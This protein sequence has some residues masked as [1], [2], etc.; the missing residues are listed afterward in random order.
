MLRHLLVAC[1]V[2]ACLAQEATRPPRTRPPHT[3]GTRPPRPTR[4]DPCIKI[5]EVTCQ[6]RDFPVCASNNQT[7]KNWCFFEKARCAQRAEGVKMIRPMWKGRCEDG[8]PTM[9]TRPTRP[10][11]MPPFN[12][13][14]RIRNA[15]CPDNED[16][17]CASNKQ[18][19]KNRCFLDKARCAGKVMMLRPL[20]RG[21]CEDG[22]PT[23][24]P[25]PTLPTRR[26][27]G[28]L[29]DRI[30]NVTCPEVERPICASNRQTYKNKCFFEKA[31]CSVKNEDRQLRPLWGGRCEDGRP[32]RPTPA[33]RPPP[34]RGPRPICERVMKTDCSQIE[35]REFPICANNKQTYRNW[36]FFEQARCENERLRPLWRGTCENPPTRPTRPRPTRP[37]VTRPEV[38]RPE[39]TRPV[40]TA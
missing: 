35:Q 22:R 16:P 25:R 4:P 32:T 9:P 23:M 28:N 8:R 6:E 17:V 33:T 30:R 13:C 29:C 37:E 38:T 2:A 27:I 15:T 26:P 20:W 3:D 24:P 12:F 7:Y 14:D 40:P 19:Y 10:T 34:T 18:T 36:C 21:R 1:F 5:Q 11:R 39:V 31:R